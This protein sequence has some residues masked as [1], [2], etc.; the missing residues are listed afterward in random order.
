MLQ[1]SAAAIGAGVL[2]LSYVINMV[3]FIIGIV[4][5]LTAAFAANLS[6]KNILECAKK[7][8]AYSYTSLVRKVIGKK[9]D[10]MMSIL[11]LI[12]ISGSCISE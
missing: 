11:I 12:S 9:A 7:T 1:L 3:G 2:N 6:L 8:S 5:I 4:F 10:R